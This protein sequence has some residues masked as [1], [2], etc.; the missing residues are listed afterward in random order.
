MTLL[1]AVVDT[2]R[3][4]AETGSRLAKRDAIAAC[5]RALASD[6][7]EIAVAFLS[8]ETRQ[9]RLGI[10]YATLS[11]LRGRAA[12]DAASLTLGEVDQALARIASTSGKGAAGERA[13]LLGELFARGTRTE[14][15]F[16][17]RL[18]VGELRQGAL[19]GV[20]IEALAAAGGVPV[21]DVRRAGMLAAISARSRALRW[22]RVRPGSRA[23]RSGCCGRCNRCS[24][25]RRRTSAMP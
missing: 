7:V 11:E 21:A 6:E 13:R 22:P 25:S 2:S 15:D 18:L 1:G 23:S 9:G 4:V 10:G 12:S 16:L 5:L 19:E 24:R 14:Q 8:G 3:R 17:V 20:M